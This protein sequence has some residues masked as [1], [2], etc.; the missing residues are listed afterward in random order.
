LK[1]LKFYMIDEE[2]QNDKDKEKKTEYRS[3][4]MKLLK[5]MKISSLILYMIEMYEMR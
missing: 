1:N 4:F 3:I 5:K 2:N